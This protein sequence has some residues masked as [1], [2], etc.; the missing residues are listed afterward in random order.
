[1]AFITAVYE[2]ETVLNS[3]LVFLSGIFL[4]F[5]FFNEICF[6]E[7]YCMLSRHMCVIDTVLKNKDTVSNNVASSVLVLKSH[8]H[9]YF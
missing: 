9:P 2:D 4:L 8:P 7:I 1:M 5:Y 3:W 6:Q